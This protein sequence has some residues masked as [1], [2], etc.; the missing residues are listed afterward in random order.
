MAKREEKNILI[1]L[2]FN[3][4]FVNHRHCVLKIEPEVCGWVS[5]SAG[6][7]FGAAHPTAWTCFDFLPQ[8]SASSKSNL[9]EIYNK[10]NQFNKNKGHKI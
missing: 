8:R 5:L 10:K 6:Y 3:F 4:G 2:K 1:S 9:R 7:S